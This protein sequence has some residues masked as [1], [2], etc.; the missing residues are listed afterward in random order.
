MQN[1][2]TPIQSGYPN[3][4]P[5]VRWPAARRWLIAQCWWTDTLCTTPKQPYLA[6]DM[7]TCNQPGT[8]GLSVDD[9]PNPTDC[10]LYTIFQQNNL[11]AWRP[12][13][14][15][16]T[17]RRANAVLHRLAGC[18]LGAAACGEPQRWLG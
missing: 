16:L 18:V 3:S 1:Q 9:G 5:H 17:P 15:Q 7:T 6:K 11:S 12:S 8:W 14:A 2:Y 10:H 4:D 13:R